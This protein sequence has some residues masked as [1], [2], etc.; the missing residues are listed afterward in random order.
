MVA[1]R[2]GGAVRIRDRREFIACIVRLANRV[3]HT[4]DRQGLACLAPC[5]VERV[6][7]RIGISSADGTEHSTRAVEG[8]RI[9]IGDGT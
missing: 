7:D 3:C 9:G 8:E 4:A 2:R 1:A 6:G 5:W